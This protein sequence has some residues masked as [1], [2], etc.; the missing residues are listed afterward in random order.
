MKIDNFFMPSVLFFMMLPR[1]CLANE[2]QSPESLIQAANS[3]LSSLYDTSHED[4][5]I[6][7]GSIDPRMR[8]TQ[9]Q[10]K[11][12]VF[13]P[14][15]SQRHGNT[16]IGIRC[17][18][19]KAWQIY[20]P[21]QVKYFQYVVTFKHSLTSGHRIT[22]D[23]LKLEKRNIQ[24]FRKMPITDIKHLVG[25]QLKTSVRS[26]QVAT[27]RMACAVCKGESLSI[28]ANIGGLSISM[29]GEAL[30]DGFIGK[31]IFVKNKKTLKKIRGTVIATN[32]IK[33]H[34]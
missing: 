13:L 20:V 4:V 15:G 9:C 18:K 3:F 26:G 17:I 23:D 31:T 27:P 24:Q 8:L 34:I 12:D 11:L 28:I 32:T 7:I 19:P 33:V 25:A 1:I 29:V 16:I 10:Q 30:E 2:I 21:V 5:D 6:T 14:T 22:T